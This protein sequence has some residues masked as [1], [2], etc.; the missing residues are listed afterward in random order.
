MIYRKHAQHESPKNFQLDLFTP[1]DGHFEYYAVATN[2]PLS[3]SAL[4]PFIGGR[5]A[6]E[7]TIAELKGEFALDVVPTRHHGATC[8]WQ[9]L[10]ILPSNVAR[11]LQLPPIATPR[12]RS[13]NR[14]Y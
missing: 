8:A 6:Q 7:K 10:S 3:L 13:R 14:T 4:Y 1:D 2:L 9:Q 11:S 5:G 12:H